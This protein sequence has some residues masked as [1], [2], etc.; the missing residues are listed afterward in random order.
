MKFFRA[1]LFY[2]SLRLLI[3]S[4]A[5]AAEVHYTGSGLRDPFM[6]VRVSEKHEEETSRAE[7]RLRSLTIQ[8]IFLSQTNPKAIINGKIYQEGGMLESG[9]IS[10]I[11]K[12]GVTVQLDDKKEVFIEQKIGKANEIKKPSL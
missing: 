9:K 6:R 8:G 4:A 7:Q 5:M 11:T 2:S 3:P 10:K 12:E 1:V